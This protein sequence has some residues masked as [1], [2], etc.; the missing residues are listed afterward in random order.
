MFWSSRILWISLRILQWNYY[1]YR[2]Q[3]RDFKE[4]QVSIL[5]V[6]VIYIFLN[7]V[8]FQNSWFYLSRKNEIISETYWINFAQKCREQWGKLLKLRIARDINKSLAKRVSYRHI[9]LKIPST[10]IILPDWLHVGLESKCIRP[11]R[12]K[13]P[14]NWAYSR[15]VLVLHKNAGWCRSSQHRSPAPGRT[16]LPIRRSTSPLSDSVCL[17]WEGKSVSRATLR[18][19]FEERHLLFVISGVYFVSLELNYKTHD[20]LGKREKD[21]DCGGDL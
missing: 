7:K 21:C 3:N 10:P 20:S 5:C 4:M 11:K 16:K 18:N 17:S 8:N 14:S 13:F 9:C 2:H 1:C 12:E 6:H 15:R 19:G